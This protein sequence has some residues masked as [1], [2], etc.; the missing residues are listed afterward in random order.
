[1]KNKI[2]ALL[3]TAA[4]SLSAHAQVLYSSYFMQ[5]SD[6]RHELNPALLDHGYVAM[7]LFLGYMNFN[8]TGSFG[9]KKF[10][11]EMQ[12]SWQ[13]YDNTKTNNYTTFM[14]PEVDAN[15]FLDGLRKRNTLSANFKYQLLSVAFK[16]LGG[17]NVID[18]NL[19]S[20]TDAALPKSLFEFMKQTGA[21]TDY[22][23]TSLGV[24]SQTFAELGLGHS[25]KINDRLTV[26]AKFKLLFGLAYADIQTDHLKLHLNDDYWEID[27][28][29]EAAA[30]IMK[31]EVK[32]KEN[33][34]DP[35]NPERQRFDELD[36]FKGGLGGVGMA[37]DLGA[38]YKLTDDLTL[39][40]A[41]TDLGFISWRD[42]NRMSSSGHW[43][44]DGFDED[45]YTGGSKSNSTTL[46]DQLEDLG[47]D[48]EDMFSVY[49]DGKKKK[50]QALAANLNIGAEYTLPMYNKMRFG[51]L[52]SS[53]LAGRYS[54]HQGMFS[55]NYRPASWI[56]GTLNLAFTS[57]GVT[58]GLVVDLH[59]KH[60]NFFIGADRFLSKLGKQGIPL[61]RANSSLALGISFP[62]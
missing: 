51:F 46:D 37:I 10:I 21:Q 14:H 27:G 7:P 43:T 56:E 36:D 26:G 22:D 47:D 16:G 50:R 24:R 55:A 18:L 11:Y 13:G 58:S 19:R 53:K 32:T 34:V 20:Q 40:A 38:T 49:Y 3:L 12:P 33:K 4:L 6:Y 17:Y 62:M 9:A 39:S 54:Y 42:A 52:Y 45:I 25:H 29:I 8:T 35:E 60:F 5:T 59:A 15:K 28:K 23:I 48:L 57:T 30:A 44:F 2:S 41:L 1:M 61:N 31:T